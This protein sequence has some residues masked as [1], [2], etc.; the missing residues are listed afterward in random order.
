MSLAIY[1]PLH[2]ASNDPPALEQFGYRF[3]AEGDSW[4][5][6]G[7]LNPAKNSNLLFEME[8][9][10]SACAINCAFPGDTLQ[11]IGEFLN[12]QD[13]KKLLFGRTALIWD[14][15]LLSAGGNDLIDALQARGPDIALD[16]RLL[17]LADEWGDAAQGAVRYVSE[18]GWKTFER[19]VEDSLLHIVNMRDRG[20]SAG[21]PIF[22][23]GY[24]VPTPRP[25]GAGL[26]AGPWL[27][28]A[29][30]AYGIPEAH[31]IAL[32]REF[33]GR[34]ASLLSRLA[35]DTARFANVHM[36]DSTNIAIIPAQPDSTGSDG[37]WVNEIHLTWQGYEKIADPWCAAIEAVMEAR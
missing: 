32:A 4:F 19:Y 6:I 16:K 30:V 28:P 36:F 18:P 17:L 23:H 29:L 2:L 3:L 7:A 15:I 20:P 34:L 33:I 37:D 26:G 21:C 5:T 35:G 12:N 22:M 11:H 9:K 13:F 1:S 14:G 31:R 8:F 27:L 24:A 25:A 10:L